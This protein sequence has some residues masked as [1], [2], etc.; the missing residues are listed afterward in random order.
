MLIIFMETVRVLYIFDYIW[1]QMG[2]NFGTAAELPQFPKFDVW[3]LCTF[4]KNVTISENEK[5][6]S[7]KFETHSLGEKFHCVFMCLVH[8][9]ETERIEN[10]LTLNSCFKVDAVEIRYYWW[11]I[12]PKR[13]SS[14]FMKSVTYKG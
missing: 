7:R 14:Y 10:F 5:I 4:C 6:W 3:Y 9:F 1:I 13:N 11:R 8:I 12:F 2:Y